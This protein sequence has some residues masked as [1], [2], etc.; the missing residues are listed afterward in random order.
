M[1]IKTTIKK[2]FNSDKP[3]K[4]FADVEIDGSI[5]IH[6]VAVM[7]TEKGTHISMPYTKW[8]NKDGEEKQHDVVH[9]ITS[10]ARRQIEE[11]VLAAYDS[12]IKK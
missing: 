1:V 8:K 11:S 5:V 7:E 12:H 4:A 9:P 6:S 2:M 3:L 10:S